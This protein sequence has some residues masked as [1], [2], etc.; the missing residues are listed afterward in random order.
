P[1]HARIR[2][3]PPEQLQLR[4]ALRTG[5]SYPRQLQ[6]HRVLKQRQIP[7]RAPLQ[8][9]DRLRLAPAATAVRGPR[10]IPSQPQH[11]PALRTPSFL[12]PLAHLEAFPAPKGRNT[13]IRGHG[14]PPAFLMPG[15][16]KLAV[17]TVR[18]TPRRWEKNLIF[19]QHIRPRPG[20]KRVT[21][22]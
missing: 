17:A 21:Y 7:H 6:L 12:P 8:V 14:R 5:H 13:L 4:S 16:T 10:P 3:K 19:Q 9:V 18:L 2:L 15:N 1:R 22:G 11:T 20:R